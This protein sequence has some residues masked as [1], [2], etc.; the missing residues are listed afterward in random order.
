MLV[1]PAK[2]AHLLKLQFTFFRFRNLVVLEKGMS[3]DIALESSSLTVRRCKR[4]IDAA[5][6]EHLELIDIKSEIAFIQLV[7]VVRANSNV[8]RPTFVAGP[9]SYAR[10]KSTLDVLTKLISVRRHW[11]REPWTWA[12]DDV[13]F[14]AAMRSL[15]DF[16]LVKSDV[17]TFLYMGWLQNHRSGWDGSTKLFLHLAAGNS[18]RGYK[19]RSKLTK[20]MAERFHGTPDHFNVRD[21]FSFARNPDFPI[22]RFNLPTAVSKRRRKRFITAMKTPT[23][24]QMP[25]RRFPISDY[26]QIDQDLKNPW[27]MR[28]WNIKQLL[29]EAQ[30]VAEGERQN[31]CVGSYAKQC[32]RGESSIWAMECRGTM[33]CR[34]AVTIRVTPDKRIV[35]ALGKNNRSA[36]LDELETIAAWAD[37]EGLR[38]SSPLWHRLLDLRSRAS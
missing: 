10:I 15:I 14:V 2:P 32:R 5:I 21:A 11:Q 29:T 6:H 24:S 18:V 33:T 34:P 38:F 17:P 23:V 8:L 13:S 16:L 4:L 25:W 20:S 36:K 3:A 22:A 31:H 35:T 1:R 9:N 7:S 12:S 30:L 37:Q 19:T 27:S 26:Q 28:I